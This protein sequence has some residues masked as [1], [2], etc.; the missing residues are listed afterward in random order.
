M[1][2]YSSRVG[3]AGNANAKKR[4]PPTK[5]SVNVVKKGGDIAIGGGM[6]V[7]SS[8]KAIVDAVKALPH[9]TDQIQSELGAGLTSGG[10]IVET[11]TKQT[12]VTDKKVIKTNKSPKRS[13]SIEAGSGIDV[14]GD[15]ASGGG[16]FSDSLSQITG[17][18]D[19]VLGPKKGGAL[20][21]SLQGV[22]GKLTHN[23]M[24]Q[25]LNHM[26]PEQFHVL[27][28][29]AGA[30]LPQ[31]DSHPFTPI[32][33][34]VL[35]GSFTHPRNIS[36]M[37]TR[38]I[39]R[40][41]SA[42]QLATALHQEMRD[43]HRGMDVGGGLLDSL[44]HGFTRGFE[45]LKSSLSA[46]N[47]IGSVLHSALSTGI[48]IGQVFS[49]VVES[50]FPGAGELIKSGISGAEALKAG[51][52]TGLR[53]GEALEKGLE[54]ISTVVS[55]ES[56]VSGSAIAENLE[57]AGTTPQPTVVQVPE[58]PTSPDL[59]VVQETPS[60]Q[61]QLSPGAGLG[62]GLSQAELRILGF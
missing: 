52:E 44:K 53:A 17:E 30:H 56:P 60:G 61:F 6:E 40:A 31:F 50:L 19:K 29:V 24:I 11:K 35:G 33:R 26:S 8:V 39:T 14:G 38:D 43:A 41:V 34:K 47:R 37:A 18:I 58:T 13:G 20:A 25:V 28:G 12:V 22:I 49:P 16:L 23:G 48:Q 54:G 1:V 62:G 36:K 46:G 42:Q 27:Q 57:A 5:K 4:G 51:L 32:A 45:G 55:D 21:S 3:P 59:P 2:K 10:G 7:G 15:L 9:E